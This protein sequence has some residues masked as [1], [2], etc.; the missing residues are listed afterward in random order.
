MNAAEYSQLVLFISK[1]HLPQT[2]PSTKSN[3][4]K[5]ARKFEL[6]QDG[7]LYRNSL[8]VVKTSERARIFREFHQHR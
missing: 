4:I 7:K 5:K 6:G 2:F 8:P 3:F 1:G